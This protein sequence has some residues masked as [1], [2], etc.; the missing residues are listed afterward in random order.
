M[1]LV[2]FKK[3]ANGE[4]RKNRMFSS[5]PNVFD[6][7]FTE[8]AGRDYAE[9]VP[10]VNVTETEKNYSVELSAPGFEKE[11]LK[12]AVNEGVLS[13]SG[14]HKSEKKEEKENY[15]RKEFSFG[16][17]KRSFTLPENIDENNISAKYENG[18]LRL[19]LIKSE[20]EKKPAKEISVT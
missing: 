17:F 9:F 2:T 3:P 16:S 6:D 11:N 4:V 8:F 20:P 7:F 18:I 15:T 1:T 5:F 12:I 13:I 19:E 14:E 10:A